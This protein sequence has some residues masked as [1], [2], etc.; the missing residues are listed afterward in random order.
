MIGELRAQRPKVS[1]A[2]DLLSAPGRERGSPEV[3]FARE[4]LGVWMRLDRSDTAP[5]RQPMAKH[6]AEWLAA[7]F[8]FAAL[9]PKLDPAKTAGRVLN[10][11]SR[12]LREGDLVYPPPPSRRKP[13]VR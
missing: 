13:S 9:E 12:R 11:F 3:V 4:A 7:G 10:E 8:V 1:A 2:A 6:F 5:V